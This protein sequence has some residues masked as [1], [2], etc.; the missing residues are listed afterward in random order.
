M[1][2]QLLLHGDVPPDDDED[3][4]LTEPD[5]NDSRMDL[6]EEPNLE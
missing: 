1:P 3:E 5:G 6:N 2:S 4:P